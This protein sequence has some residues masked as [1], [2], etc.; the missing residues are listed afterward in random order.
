MLSFEVKDGLI[1]GNSYSNH[2][3]DNNNNNYINY[4][5]YDSNNN[6]NN[7][8][9]KNSNNNDNSNNNNKNSNNNNNDNINNNN[10][11]NDND[12]NANN[13]NDSD[14]I[15]NDN[16]N[17]NNHSQ[18][19]LSDQIDSAEYHDHSIIDD[20]EC[21]LSMES[22]SVQDRHHFVDESPSLHQFHTQGQGPESW[23]QEVPVLS[24]IKPSLEIR[25]VP[26]SLWGGKC[27]NIRVHEGDNVGDSFALHSSP[28]SSSSNMNHGRTACDINERTSI[29]LLCN[30][31]E[32]IIKDS[33]TNFHT[34]NCDN[35][36][37]ENNDN[38]NNSSDNNNNNNNDNNDNINVYYLVKKFSPSQSPWTA[39]ILFDEMGDAK[40]TG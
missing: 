37:N 28:S 27:D 25:D 4:D 16:I 7:N 35:N 38:E 10:N 31:H 14:K 18:R 33:E 15:N 23:I 11:D 19:K 1:N 32:Y 30:S 24:D 17:N 22:S 34:N 5:S 39:N 8:N 21:S 40:I 26:D 2:S 13:D 36:S 9:N 20:E 6:N 12:N 29:G 3:N